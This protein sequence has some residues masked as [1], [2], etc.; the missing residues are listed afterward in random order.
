VIY[1]IASGL[2][3]FVFETSRRPKEKRQK[4]ATKHDKVSLYYLLAF[5]LLG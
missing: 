4:K 2:L 3:F 1:L 5:S